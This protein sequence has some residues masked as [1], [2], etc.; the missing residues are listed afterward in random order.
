MTNRDP[1]QLSS[2]A[3]HEIDE[4]L[5][6][7]IENN[8]QAPR[9]RLPPA[10]DDGYLFD[11]DSRYAWFVEG[12]R[13][14]D[15]LVRADDDLWGTTTISTPAYDEARGLLLLYR[16]EWLSGHLVLYA[17]KNNEATL[18]GSHQLWVQ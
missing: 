10:P 2:I 15:V 8:E 1:S 14:W 12:G 18:L 7:L 4:L 6:R 3:G 13:K 5:D 9:L 16:T 11:D 17:I